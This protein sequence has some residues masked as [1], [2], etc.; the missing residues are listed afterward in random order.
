MSEPLIWRA[1]EMMNRL[2]LGAATKPV[3]GQAKAAATDL[4]VQISLVTASDIAASV[5]YS[6]ASVQSMLHPCCCLQALDEDQR[7][8]AQQPCA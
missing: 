4:P 2:D 6:C 8:R 5:R 7:F 1:V 3:P